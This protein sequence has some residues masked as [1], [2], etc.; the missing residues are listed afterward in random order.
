VKRTSWIRRT[1]DAE[2]GG[3][4]RAHASSWTGSER[5]T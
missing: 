1:A 3:R 4:W 5:F 2:V